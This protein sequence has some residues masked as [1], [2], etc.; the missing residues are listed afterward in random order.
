MT[1]DESTG[2]IL[3][4]ALA[5]AVSSLGL[6]LAYYNYRKRIMKAESAFTGQAIGVIVAVVVVAG[7]IAFW[8]ATRKPELMQACVCVDV[9]NQDGAPLKGAEVT[10]K[11]V[12]YN[13]NLGTVRTDENGRACVTARNSAD[14]PR[15]VAIT[16]KAREFQA[17]SAANPVTTPSEAASCTR[18]YNC[19]DK[20]LV[21]PDKIKLDVGET[22]I[23][24]ADMA[25]AQLRVGNRG[26]ATWTGYVLPGV[27]FLISFVVTW[28]LF[29]HF[30]G[31]TLVAK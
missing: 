17:A 13:G 15:Q 24:A 25:A 18:G 9:V 22:D 16:A 7:A 23:I 12:N 11:G 6:L 26:Q 30:T 31:K 3:G 1:M 14:E 10:A 20:C 27:I 28:L 8:M 5:Y 4:M 2:K 19:P 29:K 21:L